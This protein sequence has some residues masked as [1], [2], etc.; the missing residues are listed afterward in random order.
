M[1]KL[2]NYGLNLYLGIIHVTI[3]HHVITN[4][5]HNLLTNVTRLQNNLFTSIFLRFSRFIK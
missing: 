5:K 3:I 1:L 2:Y 4:N